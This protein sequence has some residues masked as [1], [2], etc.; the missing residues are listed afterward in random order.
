MTPPVPYLVQ[1][2]MPQP[3]RGPD[4]KGSWQ[5]GGPVPAQQWSYGGPD[6]NV[7]SSYGGPGSNHPPRY[8]GP[9]PMV[10]PPYGGPWY[11][12]PGYQVNP[13][14]SDRRH[15]S[16]EQSSEQHLS[17]EQS[18]EQ[19]ISS[20]KHGRLLEAPGSGKSKTKSLSREH[21]QA[22]DEMGEKKEEDISCVKTILVSKL[23]D[24]VKEEDMKKFFESKRKSSGG[25]VEKIDINQEKQT[26]IV[27]F[28]K[29]EVVP[30]VL[31]RRPILYKKAI[32]EI[33]EFR[34]ECESDDESEEETSDSDIDDQEDLSTIEVHGMSQNT[35]CDTIQFYF[36]N[37][38]KSGGG[39]IKE[40]D[41]DA[42]KVIAIIT[43]EDA[44]VTDEVI[45]RKHVLDGRTLD[46]KMFVPPPPVQM[47][48]DKVLLRD[49]N[50]DT[51][52]DALEN[53]LELK[54]SALPK[55]LIF[56]E[57][58]I[59]VTFDKNIDFD[60][61]A[62]L[63]QK[64]KLEGSFLKAE[65]V[66]VTNCVS[67]GNLNP[68]TTSDALEMFFEN[69]RRSG[70]GHIQKVEMS[71][72]DN[73]C[74]IFFE[75]CKVVDSVCD[76]RQLVLDN[77][78]LSVH[79]HYTGL[80]QV[81]DGDGQTHAFKA[82][83]PIEI[84]DTDK[85]K[86]YAFLYQHG[87]KEVDQT[88]EAI[89]ARIDWPEHYDD[90]Q[91]SV[92]PTLSKTT[93]NVRK[94]A[95]TWNN[96]VLQAMF[97]IEKSLKIETIKMLKEI[98]ND[99]FKAKVLADASSDSSS[100]HVSYDDQSS[101]VTL[102]GYHRQVD[103]RA[104]LI[105]ESRIKAENDLERKKKRIRE[106]MNISIPKLVLLCDLDTLKI[107]RRDI[108]DLA[109]TADTDRGK[110]LFEG[111]LTDIKLAQVNIYETMSK[112]SHTKM[113]KQ[114]SNAALLFLKTDAVHQY[115]KSKMKEAGI[116]C[117]WEVLPS[118]S[119]IV[120]YSLTQPDIVKAADLIKAR[121]MEKS[122][123]IDRLSITLLSKD[124]WKNIC[125]NFKRKFPGMVQVEADITRCQ[126][127]ILTI[128][129]HCGE[130]L[131][132]I[133]DFLGKNTIIEE[134]MKLEPGISK[135][136]KQYKRDKLTLIERRS[137]HGNIKISLSDEEMVIR[138][139]RDDLN[140]AKP[141]VA[142]L[143]SNVKFKCFSLDKPGIQEILQS[144]SWESCRCDI[145]T[146]RTCIIE[147]STT[148]KKELTRSSHPGSTLDSQ[149]ELI[150][151]GTTKKGAVIK[152]FQGDITQ[153]RADVIVNA[154]NSSLNHAGGLA[155][156]IVTKGGKSIQDECT[157]YVKRKGHLH[158][159]DIY[160]SKP[161]NLKCK[162]IAHANSPNWRDGKQR[163]QEYLDG[164]VWKSLEEC[165]RG[166][167]TSIAMPALGTGIFQYPEDKATHVIIETILEFMEEETHTS[168]NEIYL[169][170]INHT[171][172]SCFAEELKGQLGEASVVNH[173]KPVNDQWKRIGQKDKR[174]ATSKGGNL[175]IQIVKGQIASAQLQAG[176]VSSSI[177]RAA[178]QSI[179]DE[180][181][182]GYPAGIQYGNVATTT[183]GQLAC[184]HIFHGA[185]NKYKSDM[186]FQQ[187]QD[188]IRR[189]LQMADDELM[190]SISF[191]ALGTG[192][193]GYPHDIVAAEMFE[194]VNEFDPK[195]LK[196]VQFVI[197]EKD[198]KSIQAFQNEE[199]KWS[200]ASGHS[201][202]P[203]QSDSDVNWRQKRIFKSTAS[204]QQP[205]NSNMP[206]TKSSRKPAS[207]S[208]AEAT[209]GPATVTIRVGNITEAACEAIVCSTDKHCNMTD[210]V[211]YAIQQR[212]GWDL[213]KEVSKR[214]KTLSRHGIALIPIKGMKS[215]SII[216]V[217]TQ[218]D[219]EKSL[220]LALTKADEEGHKSLA[221]PLIS[222]ETRMF[223]ETL[224][225][226]ITGNSFKKLEKIEVVLT[227]H[228]DFTDVSSNVKKY[229]E[230][231]RPGMIG[232]YI[233]RPLGFAPPDMSFRYKTDELSSVSSITLVIYGEVENSLDAAYRDVE[234]FCDKNITEHIVDDPLIKDFSD[235]QRTRLDEFKGS[236]GVQMIFEKRPPRIR[237]SGLPVNV[238]KASNEID[239][240]IMDIQRLHLT[241]EREKITA[242]CVE[243]SVIDE[244]D[245]GRKLLPYPEELNH[246][247][248][249]DYQQQKPN[250]TFCDENGT[251]Y[252]IDFS[253]M[254][255]YPVHDQSDRAKVLRKDKLQATKVLDSGLQTPTTWTPMTDQDPVIVV[256]MQ[257]TDSEYTDV[258]KD[259]NATIGKDNP[260]IVKIE[261]IQNQ[262]LYQQYV[263][264][265]AEID[266]SCGGQSE[267]M[268]WHGTA[269]G[270]VDSINMYGFNRSFCGKNATVHGDGVYF[271]CSSNYSARDTYSPTNPAGQKKMYR[272]RV[273]AGDFTQGRGGIRVPPA[274]KGHILYDSVVDDTNNP[275]MFIIFNDT[276]A[277]PEYLITFTK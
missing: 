174:V 160:C 275:N 276:Q 6:P 33:E 136:F 240:M 98:W 92:S 13:Q 268:L 217:N 205:N 69:G 70:G 181:H 113:E 36:E 187:F 158:D 64:R 106:E 188:F 189:C 72:V 264:K 273:L 108:P 124:P 162:M 14:Q 169:C 41:F 213:D 255:E 143:A 211:A 111:Q 2:G 54:A 271:A 263:T 7:P 230:S 39:N 191:P 37:K 3:Y 56:G 9:G 220:R 244:G 74:I 93:K 83:P 103:Q 96:D 86:M 235:T 232:K 27:T 128:A 247:I 215:K 241:K 195:T 200:S 226:V 67:V 11:G 130:I 131:E 105:E 179:Q 250:A 80:G 252:E 194:I 101:E 166:K 248:E 146:R 182:V 47:C 126:V 84:Q 21:K 132:T 209:F 214:K 31:A 170:D 151:T 236:L 99:D 192:N 180:C 4:P 224:C 149:P 66:A 161:G 206:K 19:Q 125:D 112:I 139:S 38:R 57:E 239:H 186:A 212:T 159:G 274:K 193:L 116:R 75:D 62:S 104:R 201:D 43:F 94:M 29:A 121:V 115:L 63:C 183:G 65:R 171:A 150:A 156:S 260:T 277:Y 123:Q 138:G 85:I 76:R 45:R 144:D 207:T 122:H 167:Y 256:P 23:P 1:P 175:N 196:E 49:V 208:E 127:Q 100:V 28:Q 90:V 24:H 68:N 82:P 202:V 219:L 246:T 60:T 185:L 107:L 129:E 253:T 52:R 172:V 42:E 88:L 242:K 78:T 87:R 145:E 216:L 5:Y 210:G 120:L 222:T 197:Y 17:P 154:A 8:G 178:G 227:K 234:F 266:R 269:E 272:C 259:F 153:L 20:K 249:N 12:F 262:T 140:H 267:K 133:D 89:N 155:K 18:S 265:K 30:R 53:F 243:W 231:N 163:E 254:E 102:I 79:P 22:D 245:D 148:G 50:P 58:T 237:L 184:K 51:S 257:E 117:S 157:E 225:K 10:P 71:D 135:Y 152:T 229:V 77:S 32:I 147:V 164:V 97:K 142:D 261:R 59:L 34:V 168:V 221:V 141:L 81:S 119:S 109:V 177:L 110:L 198:D 137:A 46:V 228:T 258:L 165:G 16:P 15:I 118:D 26:A 134:S 173:K 204:L 176:A 35:S 251:R 44:S 73:S 238:K 114:F 95:K 25:P 203:T 91:F 233:R 61:F 223:S 270:A 199:T 40:F 218:G 190:T 48:E 55:S